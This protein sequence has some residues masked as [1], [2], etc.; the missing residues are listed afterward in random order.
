M[1]KDLAN[2]TISVVALAPVSIATDT[3]TT[4]IIVDMDG[5]ESGKVSLLTGVVT[6]GDIAITQIEESA[7]SGMSGAT[8]IPDER[9]INKD[10]TAI[11]TAAQV[12][13]WGFIA[14]YRYVQVTYTTDNSANL[15][16]CSTI[17][18]GDLNAAPED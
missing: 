5:A 8:V 6:A 7:D 4:S 18:Q 13:T 17:E 9:L 11:T 10:T 16:A 12:T 3:A 2:K 15:L 14:N 1:T